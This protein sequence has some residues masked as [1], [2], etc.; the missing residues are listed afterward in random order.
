MQS[1]LRNAAAFFRDPAVSRWSKLWGLLAVVYAVSPVDAIPDVIPLFGW[2]D[3]VG[4]IAAA[5]AWY[6]RK[7][8]A[9]QKP[10]A[11]ADAPAPHGSP[12]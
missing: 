3:D 12:R 10:V 7:I 4:V 8:S 9:Y 5:A 2:F 6:L 11:T 1:T